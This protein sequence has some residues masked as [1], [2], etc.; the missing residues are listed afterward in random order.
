MGLLGITHLGAGWKVVRRYHTESCESSTFALRNQFKSSNV[1]IYEKDG[2]IGNV[3]G[4][5]SSIR[6]V[7]ESGI[8]LIG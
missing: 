4:R 1:E 2:F 6:F 8:G 3:M 5:C 7:N